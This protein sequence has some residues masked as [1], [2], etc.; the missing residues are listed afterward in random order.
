MEHAFSLA[1]IE[2]VC[3]DMTGS[4]GEAVHRKKSVC[5]RG[6]QT[7]TNILVGEILAK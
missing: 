4:T 3:A 6:W 7:S 1:Q 5:A 2:Q